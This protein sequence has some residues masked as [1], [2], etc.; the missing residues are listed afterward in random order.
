MIPLYSSVLGRSHA[1]SSRAVSS[2]G[3]R[4][5]SSTST[6]SQA[7]TSATPCLARASWCAM[8][9]SRWSTRSALAT[10]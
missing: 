10:R 4:P 2:S 3:P 6:W 8:R 5:F 7:T 1:C 9:A